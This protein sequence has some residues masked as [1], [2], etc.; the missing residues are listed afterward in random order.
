MGRN[1]NI[2]FFMK[3]VA[4]A[5]KVGRKVI[6]LIKLCILFT[7]TNVSLAKGNIKDQNSGERSHDHRSS[8]FRLLPNI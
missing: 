6:V 3:L 1:G 4:C 5:M 7:M 8:G 2:S